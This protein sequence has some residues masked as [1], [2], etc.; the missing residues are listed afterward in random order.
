MILGTVSTAHLL[1]RPWRGDGPPRTFHTSR[2]LEHK[3]N[4]R[5]VAS[6]AAVKGTA[7][8]GTRAKD[9]KPTAARTWDSVESSGEGKVNRDIRCPSRVVDKNWQGHESPTPPRTTRPWHCTDATVERYCCGEICTRGCS[10]VSCPQ[11]TR[12]TCRAFANKRASYRDETESKA[13]RGRGGIAKTWV[14]YPEGNP[15]VK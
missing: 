7:I 8:E 12:A 9:W 6:M 14:R 3:D 2:D 10:D 11:S 13:H 4:L 1:G 5:G 15:A